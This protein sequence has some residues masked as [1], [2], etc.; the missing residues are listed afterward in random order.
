MYYIGS[1]NNIEQRLAKHNAGSVP[2]TKPYRPWKL[3][4]TE[5]FDTKS[6]ASIREM[7][8]KSWKKRSAIE[9]LLKS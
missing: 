1:T 5:I 3:R 8:L 7:Q 2:S 4:K 6:E 9:R